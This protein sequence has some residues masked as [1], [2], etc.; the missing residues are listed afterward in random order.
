MRY[1][2]PAR[3]GCPS[4]KALASPHF[5][6]AMLQ[7][8]AVN[9]CKPLKPNENILQHLQHEKRRARELSA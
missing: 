1:F 3:G 2:A 9:I 7:V 5:V 4:K 8:I 6:A